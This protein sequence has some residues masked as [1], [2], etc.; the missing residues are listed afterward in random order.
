MAGPGRGLVHVALGRAVCQSSRGGVF[1]L[2]ADRDLGTG[3]IPGEHGHGPS[4]LVRVDLAARDLVQ[5][6]GLTVVVDVGDEVDGVRTV[7]ALSR[8]ARTHSGEGQ[9]RTAR[10]PSSSTRI[11]SEGQLGGDVDG[12][13]R[14]FDDPPMP[15]RQVRV[16]FPLRRPHRRTAVVLH[17]RVLQ[18][19]TDYWR[20]GVI[21]TV[22]YSPSGQYQRPLG[23]FSGE[24]RRGVPQGDVGVALLEALV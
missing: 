14:R 16:Q 8:V 24:C 23:S 11:G 19:L 9:L 4:E 12:M 21:P 15:G 1:E 13:G 18:D 6:S 22:R 10:L 5:P 3:E 20:E 2:H 7:E 17:D